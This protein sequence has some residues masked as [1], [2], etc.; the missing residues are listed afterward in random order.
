MVSIQLIDF[1]TYL[2]AK[3]IACDSNNLAYI[4]YN[5]SNLNINFYYLNAS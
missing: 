3:S 4:I 5:S 2:F 1:K